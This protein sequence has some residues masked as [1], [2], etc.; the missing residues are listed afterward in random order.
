M[1][2]ACRR[3][4]QQLI[5]LHACLTELRALLCAHGLPDVRGRRNDGLLEPISIQLYEVRRPPGLTSGIRQ[6][7]RISPCNGSWTLAAVT[8]QNLRTGLVNR[9]R[10]R[11]A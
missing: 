7:S 10:F 5:R 6:P 2:V 3:L 1:T 9:A 4:A 8:N 11:L